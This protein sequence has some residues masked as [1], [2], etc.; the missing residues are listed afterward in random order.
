MSL[1][2][3]IVY[4]YKILISQCGDHLLFCFYRLV[5]L[6]LVNNMIAQLSDNLR[7][8]KSLRTLW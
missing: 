3:C 2:C 1:L 7:I 4:C 6:V 8:M 5:T